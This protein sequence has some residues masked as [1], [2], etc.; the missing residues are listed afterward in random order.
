VRRLD[1]LLR[2]KI[3]A[4]MAAR[5]AANCGGGY[6]DDLLG[7]LLEAWSPEPGR[8]HAG[9]DDEGTTTT[10]LTTGEVIDECK[11]FFGAGQETTATLLVWTMFLLSTHPQW[12]D[13]VREEVLREFRGDVPTTDTLSRLKL[14]RTQLFSID[15]NK[16]MRTRC[17]TCG[18]VR[19]CSFTWFCW[20]H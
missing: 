19:A 2:A 12:Q 16:T 15:T 6:G 9:S 20:R 17:M 7:L 5:V 18:C 10:T 4:M 14:V 1:K 11:T 8:R 3:T 13:K